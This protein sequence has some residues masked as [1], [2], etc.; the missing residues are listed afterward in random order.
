[1]SDKKGMEPYLIFTLRHAIIDSYSVDGGED[2]IPSESWTL[3][4]RGIEIQY[5]KPTSTP[6]NWAARP[7]SCGT[8]KPATSAKPMQ[9]HGSR[10]RGLPGP[11]R[12]FTN[13]DSARVI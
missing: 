2:S 5:K 10:R 3:A 9:D 8:W 11:L 13:P 4:Y 12:I 6:A 7:S 1:M